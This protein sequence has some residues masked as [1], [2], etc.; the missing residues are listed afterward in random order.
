MPRAK[1]QLAESDGNVAAASASTAPNRA[2]RSKVATEK[3][4]AS[5]NASI[6]L[7]AP[8]KAAPKRSKA[9]EKVKDGTSADAQPPTA[10]ISNVKAAEMEK[11]KDNNSGP[12][13]K[14]K[15]QTLREKHEAENAA[16]Q[17]AILAKMASPE[18]LEYRCISRPWEDRKAEWADDEDMDEEPDE[19]EEERCIKE[20]KKYTE[21]KPDEVPEWPWV[22][23]KMGNYLVNEYTDQA[24]RRDQDEFG[25]YVYNDYNGYGLQEVVENQLVAFHEE[26]TKKD[27][28]PHRVFVHMEAMALWLFTSELAP[29][30]GLDDGDRFCATVDTIGRALLTALNALERADLLKPDS[31]VKNL[32][33]VLSMFLSIADD[34]DGVG[35]L[36]N[37][38][39]GAD[40]DR[41]WLHAVVA[42]AQAHDIDLKG[43]G[44][45]GTAE[46]V[47]KFDGMDMEDFKK[48]GP[49]RW[50][51]KTVFKTFTAHWAAPSGPKKKTL[52]GESFDI[53]K[54]SA[55]Y[56]KK[57]AFDRKDPLDMMDPDR[58]IH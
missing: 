49:D 3:N 52:G 44:I 38:M 1:R 14:G 34:L 19:K 47:Y 40:N 21:A 35:A 15:K 58:L 12:A 53:I 41:T 30:V 54:K 13:T 10:T 43:K 55:A 8:K 42:Y 31:K 6:A 7:E 48:A 37:D 27:S 46:A 51:F 28:D 57:H 25:M 32:P 2:K 23:T 26:Y 11:E 29:W 22:V 9:S 39:L 20:N 4:N 17:R 45:Y 33:M 16:Q 56:R 18:G 36:E 50:G 24:R 5:G